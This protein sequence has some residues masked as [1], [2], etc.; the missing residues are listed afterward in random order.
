MDDGHRWRVMG[1][2]MVLCAAGGGCAAALPCRCAG[3]G[4][5]VEAAVVAVAA[6]V[7]VVVTGITR[8]SAGVHACVRARAMEGEGG[9]GG[10]GG[11]EGGGDP[12][13]NDL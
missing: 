3:G 4:W 12:T 7:W 10:E 6:A 13:P 9:E 2:V 5:V 11:R 8:A 1:W